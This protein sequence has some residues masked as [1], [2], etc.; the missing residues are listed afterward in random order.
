MVS[1][2]RVLGDMSLSLPSA[3]DELESCPEGQYNCGTGACVPETMV[4]DGKD[5]CA[6]GLDEFFCSE[7]KRDS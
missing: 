6:S 4:C 3:A 7:L 5:D 2:S 1:G